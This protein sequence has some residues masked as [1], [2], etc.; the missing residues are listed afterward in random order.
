MNCRIALYLPSYTAIAHHFKKLPAD[1]RMPI[2][3]KTMKEVEQWATHDYLAGLD[4]R[5]CALRRRSENRRRPSF[6][7]YRIARANTS[8]KSDLRVD[9]APF[10][11]NLLVDERKVIGR[12]DAPHRRFQSR[13]A[14]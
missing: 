8:K 12:F 4:L 2:W 9:P 10:A 6:P 5:A 1:F 7:L 3:R 11:R 13:P 14:F